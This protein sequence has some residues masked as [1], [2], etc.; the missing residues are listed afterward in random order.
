MRK[1]TAASDENQQIVEPDL[2]AAVRYVSV[3][4]SEAENVPRRLVIWEA[5][6]IGEADRLLKA[7]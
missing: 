1:R 4:F 3:S 7:A 5:I 6:G 2:W